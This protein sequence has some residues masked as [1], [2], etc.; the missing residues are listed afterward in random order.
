[1]SCL[2]R[3]ITAYNGMF[4]FTRRPQLP[5]STPTIYIHCRYDCVAPEFLTTTR[6]RPVKSVWMVTKCPEDWQNNTIKELCEN[7][8]KYGTFDTM[9]PVNIF[10]PNTHY[11]NKYCALCNSVDSSLPLRSWLL[12]INCERVLK[13]PDKNLLSSLADRQCNIVYKPPDKIPV[14]N[15]IKIPYTISRCNVT[16][17]W[18]YYNELIERGCLSFIDPFNL[19][20][21]NYFCYLCNTAEPANPLICTLP[22]VDNIE[23]VAPPCSAIMSLD[24]INSMIQDTSL[25]CNINTQFEDNK[26]VGWLS[27][28]L[29]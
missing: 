8:G 17:K 18:K 3:I 11:R 6:T 5:D 12:E 24:V 10:Y 20:Y 16:G 23:D 25:D 26:L 9:V 21:M 27:L 28:Q 1:M 13:M 4:E 2:I 14:E 22:Q 19:T 7:P 29:S 15:C